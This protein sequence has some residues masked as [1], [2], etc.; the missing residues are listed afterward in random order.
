MEKCKT[1]FKRTIISFLAIVMIIT[2]I[3]TFN[4]G[5]TAQA[6]SK[7]STDA[8]NWANAQ[9]GKSL[10]Y[11][12]WYGA[13]CVD[14]IMYYY[15]YLGV[16]P[17][18]GNGCDYATNS[19]P[20]GWQRI[21]YYSG[22]SAKPGDIA[23]WTY[24]SSAYG[25]VAIVTNADKNIMYVNEQNGS[26]GF[27]RQHSYRY[28]YGTFYGVIRPNFSG[29]S[30]S[31]PSISYSTISDGEYYLK[32]NSSG[33]YLAVSEQKDA[34]GQPITLS[35]KSSTFRVN[36]KKDTNGYVM[37]F[38]GVSSSRVVN[39]YADVPTNGTKVTLYNYSGSKSQSWGFQAVSG[40]YVIRSMYNSNLCLTGNGTGTVTVTNYTGASNQI[41]SLEKN[42]SLASLPND[43]YAYIIKNDG[44]KHIE[45]RNNNVQ[46]AQNG[47]DSNDPK[48]IWHFV[49]T[50]D[51]YNGAYKIIN[52]YDGTLLNIDNGGSSAGTNATSWK[53]LGNKYQRWYIYNS[54][55]GMCKIVAPSSSLCIDAA[56]NGTA[57]GTN[58][59]LYTDN[60]T[61]AQQFK[62]YNVTNDGRTY[63]KPAKPA[64]TKVKSVT[65][66]GDNVTF[67]WNASS[68][69]NSSFDKRTYTLK[70]YSDSTLVKTVKNISS[71]SYTMK[72]DPGIYSVKVTAVNTKYSNYS[73]T[74]ESVDFIHIG[75][76]DSVCDKLGGHV[77]T[78]TVK[79][80]TSKNGSVT[81][82]CVVCGKVASTSTIAKI[83]SVKLSATSYK[84]DGNTKKPG[85]TVTDSNGKK[86]KNGTDYSVSYPSGRKN[87]GQYTVTV[88][89]K[90][91]YS[92]TKKL[93]FKICPKG[94]SISKLTAGKNQFTAKWN[95]QATQT[96]G[97]QIQYSTA[98]DMSSAKTVTVSKNGTTSATVKKLKKSKTY[99]VRVRTY[100]TV[101]INGE[102]KKIC[103][104]WSSIKKVKTK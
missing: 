28:T 92:G 103:S 62:I 78:T 41:W 56:N 25:H 46:I 101:K 76:L 50:N 98:S 81:K 16:T 29:S 57:G 85:V 48:Q 99:Y 104:S 30:S 14:Y 80:T 53:D 75:S 34:N 63:S 2:M 8:V 26:Q 43:F 60:G 58:I 19:L 23:V 47:N 94:T 66:N 97:Y 13:Q 4:M 96:T 42:S 45:N 36:I 86:L 38:P 88:T 68:L 87:V 35:N 9:V 64:A 61:A 93:T 69:K 84:Y 21:K 40:G 5:I 22:F 82:K 32:C 37:R 15:N 12:K 102:N 71:T 33:Q 11:D 89:F 54:S 52:E 24:A 77:Y 65:Y 74:G 51:I 6:T 83:S 95:K 31:Q 55:N 59:Q 49:K 17:A 39:Q 18:S 90:G 7:T 10:D 70:I 20:T 67:K 1:N 91:N 72:L 3:P 100:K 44:W 27:V 73:T 79:A